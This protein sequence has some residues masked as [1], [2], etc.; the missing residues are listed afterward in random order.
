MD[1]ICLLHTGGTIG[2]T[3]RPDGTLGPPSEWHDI[4]RDV[5][6]LAEVAD[7]DF[8]P[9]FA[10]DSANVNHHDWEVMAAA[11]HQRLGEYAGFVIVHGTDTMHFSAAALS[12]ALG[13]D[14]PCPVV[15]TGA[16]TISAVAHGDARTNLLRACQVAQADLGEVVIAFGTR[17]I[18][19]CRAEKKDDV[20]FE[21][22]DSPTQDPVAVV[23]EHIRLGP[24]ARRRRP[25]SYPAL[26]GRFAGGV[27]QLSLVP[28]LRPDL[29][30]P[31][32][33]LPQCRGVILQSFGAGSVPDQPPYSFIELIERC[34][35]LAKPVVVASA[36]A[37]RLPP[38][39]TRHSG[40]TPGRRAVAAGAIRT[41]NMT[42]S[43]V[44]AKFRWALALAETHPDP[45]QRVAEIMTTVYVDEMDPL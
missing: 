28:G 43:C 22:F 6:E 45:L 13:R 9:L 16:Q 7:V 23:T 14:L 33:D 42:P 18:R 2:L 40:T 35:A 21:A 30:Y 8:V 37:G 4:L 32:I 31:V 26:N 38:L 10:K 15:F 24:G 34:G 29:F 41:G 19:G 12:F 5:P 17:V 3:R 36:V 25:D 11:V 44:L 20:A 27:L 39:P 1:R